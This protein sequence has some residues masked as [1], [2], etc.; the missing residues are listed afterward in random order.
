MTPHAQGLV[1]IGELVLRFAKVNR[2]TY[3]EDGVTEE[4]DTDH[5]V[6]LSV[7]ACALAERLYKD[8]LDLGLVAQFAIV[9]DLV[10]VYVGDTDSFGLSQAGREAKESREHGSFLLIH[11]KFN[12]VY[13]WIGDMIERYEA[14]DTKEARF[15]KTIDKAM[16]KITHILNG[17][18]YFKKRGL[19]EEEMWR[20]Y[21]TIVVTAE[22]K[23]GAEFKEV[24]EM[25]REL[26]VMV[27]EKSYR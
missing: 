19:T 1:D 21:E 10:E 5:T 4:S 20:D 8:V 6:M 18:A 13:P 23:Y 24:T 9:H 11:D 7:C 22:E 2:V 15:V 12:T 16:P 14:L 25:M 3:H 17:G 26:M 27:R